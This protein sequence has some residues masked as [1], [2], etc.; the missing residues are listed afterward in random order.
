ML[1]PSAPVRRSQ[2]QYDAAETGEKAADKTSDW[3]AKQ[4]ERAAQ[5]SP[6]Q[7]AD[8][9]ASSIGSAAQ[10]AKNKVA[11]AGQYVKDR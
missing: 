1:S 11:D 7:E 6:A 10:D 2:K 3:F 4:K 9:A 5:G 8:E